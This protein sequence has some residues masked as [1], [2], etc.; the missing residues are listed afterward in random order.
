MQ[1]NIMKGK[2]WYMFDTWQQKYGLNF[3]REVVQKCW[4]AWR[5]LHNILAE[6]KQ[7]ELKKEQL[8]NAIRTVLPDFRPNFVESEKSSNQL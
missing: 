8:R 7:V 6:E 4:K 5:K 2:K 1:T 3:Y